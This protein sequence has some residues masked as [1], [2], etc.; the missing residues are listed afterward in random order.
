MTDHVQ[1]Y[2]VNICK[3]RK[4]FGGPKQIQ[5]YV[6]EVVIK[7]F[8]LSHMDWGV[9]TKDHVP[10]K[11]LY[12]DVFHLRKWWKSYWKTRKSGASMTFGYIKGFFLNVTNFQSYNN[13]LSWEI[14]YCN[15]LQ[16]LLTHPPGNFVCIDSDCHPFL[17]L[18]SC[19]V[20]ANIQYFF[21]KGRRKRN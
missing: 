14:P 13:K 1:V 3:R 5:Q 6:H 4:P 2:M 19:N 11:V 17:Y 10:W 18:N 12:I 9:M 15:Y 20:L 21:M 16:P 7:G 8:T